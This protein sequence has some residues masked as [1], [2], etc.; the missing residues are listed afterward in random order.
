MSVD[1][2]N[3]NNHN[4]IYNPP[5]TIRAN[6]ELKRQTV[7]EDRTAAY[8][9]YDY[10]NYDMPFDQASDNGGA[11]RDKA[12]PTRTA[13]TSS[14]SSSS[15]SSRPKSPMTNPKCPDFDDSAYSPISTR[16]DSIWVSSPEPSPDRPTTAAT[17]ASGTERIS[18]TAVTTAIH[19]PPFV[20]RHSPR[21]ISPD[22]EI[23]RHR[24]YHHHELDENIGRFTMSP[25]RFSDPQPFMGNIQPP[26]PPQ[27]SAR[28]AVITQ[29]TATRA[30]RIPSQQQQ[31]QQQQHTTSN[32]D[33][34]NLSLEDEM[35]DCGE[36]QRR[37]QQHHHHQQQSSAE[38][39]F[40]LHQ[41]QLSKKC[42]YADDVLDDIPDDEIE[43]EHKQAP[44]YR[45]ADEDNNDDQEQQQQED[46]QNQM[47]SRNV[48]ITHK[49]RRRTRQRR[50]KQAP[51]NDDDTSVE[52]YG[53]SPVP[54]PTSLQER[55]H[56]AWKSRQKKN[57]SLRS[58]KN[59]ST[60]TGS[61]RPKNPNPPSVSF[62][63]SN[64]VHHFQPDRQEPRGQRRKEEDNASLDRSLDRSL[65]SDYTKTLESEVEDMI[66][67]IL[68]IGDSEKIKPG[69]RKY[70]DKP[71]VKRR[72]KLAAAAAA[73][74]TDG[75]GQLETHCESTIDTVDE[76]STFP[77]AEPIALAP[78][79]QKVGSSA[80]KPDK[81]K[82][83][84]QALNDSTYSCES[85]P[86][87]RSQSQSLTNDE[88]S[89]ET[90]ASSVDT[91]TVETMQTMSTFQSEKDNDEDNDPFS[92]VIVFMENGLSAMSSALGYALGDA[93]VTHEQTRGQ[94]KA[95]D[96]DME[97]TN[98]ISNDFNIFDTCSG[99]GNFIEEK[100]YTNGA[101]TNGLVDMLAKDMWFS[102]N[103]SITQADSLRSSK[104]KDSHKSIDCASM[105]ELV[106]RSLSGEVSA[107]D[108]QLQEFLKDS[109]VAI[110]AT[111][112][113]HSVHKIQGVEY[114]ESV[115]IDMTQDLKVCPVNLKL[116][117]GIIF[118][119]NDGK[120]N[121]SN[122][123]FWA[124]IYLH[125]F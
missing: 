37:Q 24:H 30:L 77:F 123:D 17:A 15:S 91:N 124:F 70:K 100:R 109:Q 97:K 41:E 122:N 16:V 47:Y 21:A 6:A 85:I 10:D 118:L 88:R 108:S 79:Q 120:T 81:E 9:G 52:N 35:K 22:E 25:P 99:A 12:V 1:N 106:T 7:Q 44:A 89:Y 80:S 38:E 95:R 121:F 59:D 34:S 28:P 20:K 68:F 93:E 119:E 60:I 72:M 62:G 69:R 33:A 117:L 114:D 36:Q 11:T 74:A 14:S 5:S 57:S 113:A 125:H 4:G 61:A 13:A 55:S 53:T 115:P 90:G 2:I 27:L 8:D 82:K 76:E 96:G 105:T 48:K 46:I 64:T 116:P 84:E 86:S 29:P 50:E 73:A 102:S 43:T 56:Q 67:D 87:F 49:V 101:R 3:N 110:L 31:Q 51:E 94:K 63:T 78:V 19:Q 98:D 65:N 26:S 42:E 92:A 40:R 107:T 104:S 111:H 23:H 112:A 71:E 83:T 32:N 39:R 54:A 58:S 103:P 45:F 66:K 75:N 18:S